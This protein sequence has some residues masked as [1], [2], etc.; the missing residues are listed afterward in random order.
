M[1]LVFS[2]ENFLGELSVDGMK[3][4]VFEGKMGSMTLF[5]KGAKYDRGRV[6]LG[7]QGQKFLSSLSI[8]TQEEPILNLEADGD[9]EAGIIGLDVF[10]FHPMT[11][12]DWKQ[13]K[14]TTLE[15]SE[16]GIQ[17]ADIHLVSK[18]GEVHFEQRQERVSLG[19]WI[20]YP[21]VAGGCRTYDGR[22]A[23]CR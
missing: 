3:D 6:F 11:G 16:E 5:E 10:D 13:K 4:V 20:G 14:R 9:L 7:L 22:A 18:V 21:P 2:L 15:L 17:Q 19:Y 12:V 8:F 1:F 23:Y